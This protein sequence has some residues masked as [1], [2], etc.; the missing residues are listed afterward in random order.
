VSLPAAEVRVLRRRTAL[1]L[2]SGLAT[3][4]AMAIVVYEYSPGLPGSLRTLG[5]ACAALAALG[6]LAATAVALAYGRARVTAPG[7]AGDLFADLGPLVPDP[8]RGRPWAFALMLA[9]FLFVLVTV[10]GIAQSDPFDGALRGLAEAVA[11][12][13]GFAVLGRFLGLRAQ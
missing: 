4:C 11:L 12:L 2:V 1:A 13:G 6:V 8:L 10:A 7:D 3:A 9:G 5:Y